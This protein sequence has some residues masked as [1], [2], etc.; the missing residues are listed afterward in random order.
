MLRPLLFLALVGSAAA[1]GVCESLNAVTITGGL[2]EGS[3]LPAHKVCTGSLFTKKDGDDLMALMGG[4][5]SLMDEAGCKLS[6]SDFCPSGATAKPDNICGSGGVMCDGMASLTVDEC[7]TDADCDEFGFSSMTPMMPC[8][9]SMEAQMK[10]ACDGLPSD[11][12]SAMKTAG[13]CTDTD[14]YSVGASSSLRATFLPAVAA[15][16]ALVATAWH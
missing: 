4:V 16:F 5:M 3:E 6:A 15:V 10:N 11:Y 9:A 7:K 1:Q 14:C 13:T 2:C 12:V 8:C